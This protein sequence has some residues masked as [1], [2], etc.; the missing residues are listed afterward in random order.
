MIVYIVFLHTLHTLTNQ[1]LTLFQAIIMYI[2][3][4]WYH[5]LCVGSYGQ[6]LS[7]SNSDIDL[8]ISRDGGLRWDQVSY[9]VCIQVH[10]YLMY[11]KFMEYGHIQILAHLCV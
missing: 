11:L 4:I 5:E 6:S 9:F 8:Y 1:F 2:H 10:R 7:D 3:S